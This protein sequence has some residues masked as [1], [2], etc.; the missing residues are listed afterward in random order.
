MEG[1]TDVITK[2]NIPFADYPAYKKIKEVGKAVGIF[3]NAICALYEGVFSE[4]SQLSPVSEGKYLPSSQLKYFCESEI[5]TG[6]AGD[7]APVMFAIASASSRSGP[8]SAQLHIWL[9]KEH[10]EETGEAG[11]TCVSWL[12]GFPLLPFIY[13]T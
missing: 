12:A 8:A 6:T 5:C 3:S 13:F 11:I 7:I 1:L 4:V 10:W 2:R 9:H